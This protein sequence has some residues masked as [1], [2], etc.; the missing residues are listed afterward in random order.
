MNKTQKEFDFE[1]YWQGKLAQAVE[2]AAHPNPGAC[3]AG[4]RGAE[5]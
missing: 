1:I 5:Q 4:G 2:K 3:D